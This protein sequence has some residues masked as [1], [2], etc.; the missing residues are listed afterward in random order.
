MYLGLHQGE[1]A[2]IQQVAESYDIS[3]N[4][5]MKIVHRLSR[6]GLVETV[7]GR[8]GGIRLALRTDQI[9]LGQ[10]VRTAEPSFDLVECFN[11]ADNHCVMSPAC[12]LQ[13]ALREALAAFFGVLDALT[14]ADI[15]FNAYQIRPYNGLQLGA[16]RV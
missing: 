11:N 6:D 15:L 8:S 3:R 10:V 7:R 12:R 4:Q 14:L 16:C 5:L 13:A 2:T 9:N 1:L